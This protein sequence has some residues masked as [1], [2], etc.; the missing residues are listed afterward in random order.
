MEQKIE[1]RVFIS[2][3]REDLEIVKRIVN[4]LKERQISV[5]FDRQN[6]SPGRWK[7]Q[8]IK[9]I[10]RSRYFVICV[11]H[12]A[13]R[14]TGD[15]RPGFQDKE[16]Q[17]AY[18]IA[19]SQP[20]ESFTIIPIRLENCRRGDFRLSSFH[21]FDL[22]DDFEDGLDRLAVHLGGFPFSGDLI[23]NQISDDNRMIVSLFG[24]VAAAN[25]ANELEKALSIINAIMSL[26]KEECFNKYIKSLACYFKGSILRKLG[27]P[28]KA[29][30]L[31]DK[32]LSLDDRNSFAWNNKGGSLIELGRHK[33]ALMAFEKA[34]E[35]N[36]KEPVD[37]IGKGSALGGMNRHEEA[38]E[39]FE[40]ALA[41]DPI[42]SLALYN[43]GY[44]LQKLGRYEEAL[45][46]FDKAIDIEPENYS[47][48][49]SKGIVLG[50]LSRHK[51]ALAA[52]EK[53]IELKDDYSEAWRNKGVALQS[54]NRD[55]ESIDAFNR[56]AKLK[57]NFINK[58]H[59]NANAA[60]AKSRA[61]D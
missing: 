15:E 28:E 25:L 58:K 29:L 47:F 7:D 61:A 51:E 6:L 20:E 49:Q 18:S 27:H 31:L 19:E 21:Q 1:N 59:N 42:N 8:I 46:S 44:A 32:S 11:S 30:S 24:K 37:W 4:G 60:D 13:L 3:A 35:I 38:L 17:A 22:F 45:I 9:A 55:D 26:E 16:L 40:S 23:D 14:K 10:T 41:F 50:N 56:A 34:L 52:F 5:W 2:Y 43:K 36:D 12:S 39:S 33:E 53:V 54:L 48:W 57:G